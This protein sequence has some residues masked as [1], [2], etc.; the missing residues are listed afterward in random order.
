MRFLFL[1]TDMGVAG[2][3]GVFTEYLLYAT[4]LC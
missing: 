3:G 1:H 2:G 4:L